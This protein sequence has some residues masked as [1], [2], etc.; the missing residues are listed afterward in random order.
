MI[1]K[2]RARSARGYRV[3]K[4]R[5][6]K[7]L[8]RMS[9]THL[10]LGIALLASLLLGTPLAAGAAYVRDEIRINLRTGPGTQYRILRGLKSGDELGILGSDSDWENVRTAEGQEGWIPEGY[11]TPRRPASVKLPESDAKLA[12]ARSEIERLKAQ[13]STQSVEVEEL[14]DLRGRV[15]DLTTS[16]VE[17]AGS[18]RWKMLATGG[19]IVLV[20]MLIGVLVP[21]GG[22]SQRT[23]R[24]KL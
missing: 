20:G 4:R 10:R 5:P 7:R 11:T 1:W 12:K 15:E 24:I 22:G 23:R 17:L 14:A 3:P 18:S 16:N 13:I 9:S 21:R 2:E 19:A 8:A 6:T